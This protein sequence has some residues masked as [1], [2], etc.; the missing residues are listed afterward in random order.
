MTRPTVLGILI[1]ALVCSVIGGPAFAQ[2]GQRFDSF[3]AAVNAF[4]NG[5]SGSVEGIY[6][7]DD[8]AVRL[9][10]KRRDSATFIT[11][12]HAGKTIRVQQ[13]VGA[14]GNLF[15]L[16]S[17]GRPVLLLTAHGGATAYTGEHPNG[18][19]VIYYGEQD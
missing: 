11:L 6:A 3:N 14:G 9:H 15:F 1:I 16:R 8:G 12:E 19:P 2:Q 10:L 5:R 17:D 7:S 4:Q 18:V 13:K